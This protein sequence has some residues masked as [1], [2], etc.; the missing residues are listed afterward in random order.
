P[1]SRLRG[2]RYRRSSFHFPFRRREWVFC[3]PVGRV[4]RP[5]ERHRANT[6][7]RT[8]WFSGTNQR[9]TH[10]ARWVSLPPLVVMSGGCSYQHPC[11]NG[12]GSTPDRKLCCGGRSA[13]ASSAIGRASCRGG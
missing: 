4:I 11:V 9:C 5:P 13:R 7:R 1:I 3:L 2:F 6:L 10:L 12:C 8:V